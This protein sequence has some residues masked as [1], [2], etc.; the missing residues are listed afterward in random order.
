[1]KHTFSV[2]GYSYSLYPVTTKDAPF[3]IEVRL[4]DMERNK[5]IHTISPDVSLQVE[6]IEKYYNTPDDY[7]F[8]V[9]NKSTGRKEGLISVYN[10]NDGKGEWGRWVMKK[11]SLAA[12]ESFYLLCRIAFEQLGLDEIY[13]R[14]LPENKKV[15][16][17][18]DSV[19]AKRR[20]VISQ[21]FTINDKTYD[22]V[23]HFVNKE[24]FSAVIKPHL[25]KILHLMSERNKN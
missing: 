21:A 10:I 12:V 13:S 9:K 14:T 25:D 15:V 17:F 19:N 11:D 20:K 2:E 16:D 7:Y 4:E 1:M 5:F 22:A 3:I 24:Q 23:E 6:W 18:H 8:L